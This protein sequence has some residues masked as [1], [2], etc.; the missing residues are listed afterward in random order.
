MLKS[1]QII[2]GDG[3]ETIISSSEENL[4]Q[5]V[6]RFVYG[7]WYMLTKFKTLFRKDVAIIIL[8]S[9][10]NFWVGSMAKF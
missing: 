8:S 10:V 3:K 9:E 1:P 5:N 4:S 6:E 7:S 2:V